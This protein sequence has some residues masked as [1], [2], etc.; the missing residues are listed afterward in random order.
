[1]GNLKVES[2]IEVLAG[3]TDHLKLKKSNNGSNDVAFIIEEYD[4][5]RSLT[6]SSSQIIMHRMPGSGVDL[7]LK[8]RGG[9]SGDIKFFPQDSLAMAIKNNGNVGIGTDSPSEKLEVNGDVGVASSL[10]AKGLVVFGDQSVKSAEVILHSSAW[11]TVDWRMKVN[12]TTLEIGST[13]GAVRTVRIGLDGEENT[14][15]SVSGDITA[16]GSADAMPNISNYNFTASYKEIKGGQYNTVFSKSGS[17]YVAGGCVSMTQDYRCR[18][19]ITVDG[20]V[21]YTDNAWSHGIPAFRYTDGCRIEA[22]HTVSNV[23]YNAGVWFYYK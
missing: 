22:R 20:E 11:S 2:N 1:M 12:G 17:G 7:D 5:E 10:K 13:S 15:L 14:K 4:S 8:T 18:L 19:K 9:D 21:E 6:L 3:E 23:D 16:G